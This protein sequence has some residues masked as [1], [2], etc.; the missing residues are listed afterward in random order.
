[1]IPKSS[2]KDAIQN[3]GENDKTFGKKDKSFLK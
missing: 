1:M 3:T 2:H